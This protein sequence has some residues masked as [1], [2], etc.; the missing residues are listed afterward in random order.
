MELSKTSKFKKKKDLK[1]FSKLMINKVLELHLNIMRF[2]D[3]GK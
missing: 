3:S 1:Q 2:E